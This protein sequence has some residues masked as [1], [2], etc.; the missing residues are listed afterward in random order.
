[1]CQVNK[2]DQGKKKK[3]SFSRMFGLLLV[4]LSVCPVYFSSK[5]LQDSTEECRKV[6]VTCAC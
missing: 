4:K 2:N 6:K 3:I 1:M 5:V